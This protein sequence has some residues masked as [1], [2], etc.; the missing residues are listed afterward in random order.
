MVG[1]G[2]GGWLYFIIC[3]FAAECA[4]RMKQGFRGE[5]E[6]AVEGR[7][8]EEDEKEEN[9]G[10]EGRSGYRKEGVGNARG[11][12]RRWSFDRAVL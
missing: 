12:G 6:R 3:I 4:Q 8:G 2:S 7:R 1:A 5:R 9:E 11:G 10:G